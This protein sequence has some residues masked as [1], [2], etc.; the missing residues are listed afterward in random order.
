MYNI[1]KGDLIELAKH[2]EFDAIIHGCNCFHTMGSG[3][4]LQLVNKWPQVLEE[5][6]RT[7]KYGDLSKLGDFTCAICS[8]KEFDLPPLIVYN[9]YTQFKFG[10]GNGG[11]DKNVLVDYNSI[12]RVISRIN[13]FNPA[14][15]GITGKKIGFPM[16]GAGL[17]GGDW[18]IISK[19]I[20]TAIAESN[21]YNHKWTLVLYEKQ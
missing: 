21:V 13:Y 10:I 7:S 5:D 19:M 2:G 9:C 12:Y 1:V 8:R 20:Y 18:D 3:I 16:L 11:Y 15:P 14:T 17:A 6:K 4:A